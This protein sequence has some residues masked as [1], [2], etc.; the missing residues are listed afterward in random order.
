MYSTVHIIHRGLFNTLYTAQLP[1]NVECVEPPGHGGPEGGVGLLV[2][3][4]EAE[5]GGQ[6]GEQPLLV[7]QER[8]EHSPPSQVGSH[9]GPGAGAVAGEGAGPGE[10]AG[11]GAGNLFRH[12]LKCCV[13]PLVA[14]R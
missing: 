11:S 4:T 14:L 1:V 12:S 7:L 9:G 8:V 6:G 5:V 13:C 3:V 2:Q 10:G